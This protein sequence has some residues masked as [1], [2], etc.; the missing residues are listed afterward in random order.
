MLKS[1]KRK[2]LF[3]LSQ[4]NI[5]LFWPPFNSKFKRSFLLYRFFTALISFLFVMFERNAK[6]RGISIKIHIIKLIIF[7]D[8]SIFYFLSYLCGMKKWSDFQK[9]SIQNRR[10]DTLLFTES[11]LQIT[12]NN[13]KE[14]VKVK[15]FHIGCCFG[16]GMY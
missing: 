14:S 12:K 3:F 5:F 15:P 8:V 9:E 6:E 4:P 1:I 10:L 16:L 7:T 2:P 11:A 13:G